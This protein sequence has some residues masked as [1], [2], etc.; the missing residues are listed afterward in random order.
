[1]I[2]NRKAEMDR[3]GGD[4]LKDVPP[5]VGDSIPQG[6]SSADVANAVLGQKGGK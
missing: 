2:A 6:P 1:M 4:Q 3:C 5:G